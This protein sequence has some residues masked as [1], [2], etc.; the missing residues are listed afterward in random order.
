MKM[1]RQ[2]AFN[3]FF[4]AVKEIKGYEA[5]AVKVGHNCDNR[6]AWRMAD[7]RAA[8]YAKSLVMEHGYKDIHTSVYYV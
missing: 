8:K 4:K 6:T 1:K 3:G 2:T 7:M 5:H